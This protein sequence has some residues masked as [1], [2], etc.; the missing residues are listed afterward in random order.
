MSDLRVT[1]TAQAFE[2]LGLKERRVTREQVKQTY[3][4]QVKQYHPDKVAHLGPELQELAARK[5]LL[6]N[7]AFQYL[8]ADGHAAGRQSTSPGSSQ[9]ARSKSDQA[10]RQTEREAENQQAEPEDRRAESEAKAWREKRARAAAQARGRRAQEQQTWTEASQGDSTREKPQPPPPSKPSGF[11]RWCERW[12]MAVL[13]RIVGFCVLLAFSGAISLCQKAVKSLQA[14]QQKLNA[15]IA[16][17]PPTGTHST[18]EE[19]R[20]ANWQRILEM[21]GQAEQRTPSGP[22]AKLSDDQIRAENHKV[23]QRPLQEKSN[24]VDTPPAQASRLDQEEPQSSKSGNPEALP[25]GETAPI[26]EASPTP[27]P[28]PSLASRVPSYEMF[29]AQIVQGKRYIVYVDSE[30]T[31]DPK[32]PIPALFKGRVENFWNLPDGAQDGDCWFVNSQHVY[33]VLVL[34]ENSWKIVHGMSGF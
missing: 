29:P 23:L 2:I 10:S 22:T 27:K 1:S 5:T 12:V 20:N 3:L 6:L 33:R 31:G 32:V 4:E 13:G 25:G 15:A 30:R 34:Q 26:A 17:T 24:A 7:L 14:D 9:S 21:R 19:E 18:S 16:A 8:M 11:D 28:M